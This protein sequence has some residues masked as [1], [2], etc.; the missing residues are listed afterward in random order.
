[1]KF[2]KLSWETKRVSDLFKIETGSTPSTRDNKYWEGG[3]INWLTPTDLSRNEGN[4]YIGGSERKVTEVAL[5][6][7][8]LTLLPRKSLILST[9]A[10]VGYVAVLETPAVFNQGCK[11][12]IPKMELCP[13]Y[14]YYCLLSRQKSLENRSS[15]STFKELGKDLLERF[16]LPV[17]PINQQRNIVDILSLIDKRIFNTRDQL[18]S[19]ETIKSELISKSFSA[20]E[21]TVQLGEFVVLFHNGIWGDEPSGS[22]SVFPVVRS[23]EIRADGEIDFSTAALRSIDPKRAERYLLSQGDILFVA[24][25]GSQDLVGRAAYYNQSTKSQHVFSNFMV[26]LR[27]KNI[28]PKYLFYAFKSDFYL[29]HLKRLQQTS[30]GL[31]NLPKDEF[32]RFRVPICEMRKQEKIVEMLSAV[33]FRI[34]QERRKLFLLLRLKKK[35]MDSL[36]GE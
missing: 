9:R 26:R 35:F 30:T 24:S 10:P 20:K 19:T 1:M 36:L 11:G 27:V 22:G 7:N 34:A 5:R 32:L 28:N 3:T 17:P 14:Y 12:L 25:S 6:E 8:N 16:E 2:N 21:N 4:A 13:E 29:K 23:T 31:R 15:G 33:D 18:R